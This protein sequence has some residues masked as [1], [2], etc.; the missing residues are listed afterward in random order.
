MPIQ[1]LSGDAAFARGALEAGVAV[2]ASYPGSPSSG[3]VQELLRLTDPSD[4]YVEWSTNEKVA[5]ELA[6]GASIAGSRA[7]V[8]V[9][10]VGMNA[11]VDPLMV[12]NLTGVRG[13]MVVLLGDDPG[14][15]G[16]QND[17]DTRPL[18]EF[19]ELPLL[20]PATPQAAKDLMVT[21][22]EISEQLETLVILR[23][24]R[25]FSQCGADVSVA[26]LPQRKPRVAYRREACR[27]VPFPK[28]AVKM[29]ADLHAK[30]QRLQQWMET[31]SQNVSFGTGARGVVAVGFAASKLDDVLADFSG[32]LRRLNLASVFPLPRQRVAGFLR[33]CDEVLV[34]EENE[35]YVETQLKAIAYDAELHVSIHG[36][37]SGHV[38][39][40][41][42]LFRWQIEESLRQFLGEH[43]AQPRYSAA[44]EAAELPRRRDNCAGCP[45]RAIVETL[46]EVAA[47]LDLDPMVVGDPGCLVKASDL[48]DAKFA[49]GSAVAAAQGFLRGGVESRSIAVFGD[50]AFFHTSIP[51]VIN[52]V[53][54]GAEIHMLVLD[55]R[56][57]VTSGFQP[58]PGSAETARGD[59]APHISIEAIAAACGVPNV[60]SVD[61]SGDLAKLRIAFL[62]FLQ[63]DGPA[64]L[65]VRQ[66]CERPEGT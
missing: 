39:R 3:T 36:K 22:F 58:N 63:A 14:A 28:N 8:C 45:F 20:E 29:H 60:F 52:A 7:L 19:A 24:T 37:T 38:S 65:V 2:V 31:I 40:E 18:A 51:G 62:E 16:S 33:E 30:V 61:P 9:K 44:D 21:A 25:S 57:T 48:F 50:S 66:L 4:V 54:H 49:M 35:P 1:S 11:L 23:E 47:E 34:L 13:G 27:Y 59:P 53:Q 32:E 15:Y 41:G 12:A 6:L 17:Q 42:E 26:E 64:L 10:S 56:S 43:T 5:F 46:R 55:N